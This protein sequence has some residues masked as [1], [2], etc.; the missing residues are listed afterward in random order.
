[1]YPDGS[2]GLK[3]VPTVEMLKQVIGS[4]AQGVIPVKTGIQ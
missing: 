1:M 4:A 2:G 3:N